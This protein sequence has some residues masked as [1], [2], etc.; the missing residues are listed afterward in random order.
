MFYITF[1]T[2]GRSAKPRIITTTINL[3]YDTDWCCSSRV[4]VL[5]KRISP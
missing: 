5:S 3:F 2:F 4:Q 1:R